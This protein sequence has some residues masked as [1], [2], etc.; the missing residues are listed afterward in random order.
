M[1][2]SFLFGK[3]MIYDIRKLEYRFNDRLI[4][5]VGY[6]ILIIYLLFVVIGDV[7]DEIYR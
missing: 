1:L 2:I 3:K 5:F 6:I 7:F 4:F